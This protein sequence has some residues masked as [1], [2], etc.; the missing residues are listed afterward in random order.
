MNGYLTTSNHSL[1]N[2]TQLMIISTTG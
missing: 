1:V 2:L